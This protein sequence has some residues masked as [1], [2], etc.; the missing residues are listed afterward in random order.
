M[1]Q[2]S[3]SR[4]HVKC[5]NFT[6]SD[7]WFATVTKAVRRGRAP[8]CHQRAAEAREQVEKQDSNN[9]TRQRFDRDKTNIYWSLLQVGHC[10]GHNKKWYKVQ[11]QRTEARANGGK[12][13]S[14]VKRAVLQVSQETPKDSLSRSTSTA[15]EINI[16]AR[17]CPLPG[18]LACWYRI[19]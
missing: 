10:A 12:E 9:V 14:P 7:I 4:E 13:R 15:P 5:W 17:A 19:R 18:Q 2:N 6:T 16:M 8:C 11:R 3:K 1:R